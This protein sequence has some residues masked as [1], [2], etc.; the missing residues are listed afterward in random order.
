MC[1]C[2]C[3]CMYVCIYMCV[4]ACVRAC[5]CV[6]MYVYT[7]MHVCVCMSCV[8]LGTIHRMHAAAA[9]HSRANPRFRPQLPRQKTSI[10]LITGPQPTP[11]PQPPGY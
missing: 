5:V 3:V 6:C 11:E 10:P 1:V 4:C 2:V 9:F 7:Y 8:R